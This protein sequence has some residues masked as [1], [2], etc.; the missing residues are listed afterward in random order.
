MKATATVATSGFQNFIQQH[1]QLLTV[2]GA[3][4]VFL[5]FYTKEVRLEKINALQG[6]LAA[7]KTNARISD[8]TQNIRD[9]IARLSD[10]VLDLQ[11]NG[12]N[13]SSG[14]LFHDEY[15]RILDSTDSFGAAQ[16]QL[17]AARDLIA[18]LPLGTHQLD[19]E[20]ARLEGSIPAL[21]HLQDQAL[22]MSDQ[23]K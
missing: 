21:I 20:A 4:I 6:E 15:M 22:S 2:I 1:D 7:A 10:Q 12:S 8:Q 5:S 9:D 16:D 13:S 18:Q 23:M 14:S 19:T 11:T 3:L 17:S